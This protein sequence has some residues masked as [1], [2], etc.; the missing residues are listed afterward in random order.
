MLYVR[1]K[2]VSTNIG[3]AQITTTGTR[4]LRSKMAREAPT[5]PYA[6]YADLKLLY[7]QIRTLV[8]VPHRRSAAPLRPSAGERPPRQ[9]REPT[10]VHLDQDR[11]EDPRLT[12]T[13]SYS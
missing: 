11:R 12:R 13:T 10:A 1:D 4:A 3:E 7:Q 6:L 2:D 9:D 8:R 5:V